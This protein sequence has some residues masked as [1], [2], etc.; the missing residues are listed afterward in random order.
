VGVPARITFPDVLFVP[1]MTVNLLSARRLLLAG[2]TTTI[3]PDDSCTLTRPG[4]QPLQAQAANGHFA[5]R[6]VGIMS[7]LALIARAPTRTH[8]DEEDPLLAMTTIN[9]AP[10]TP[11]FPAINI[12]PDIADD[13]LLSHTALTTTTT[14]ADPTTY[15]AAISSPNA[16]H[17]HAAMLDELRSL[18]EHGTWRLAELPG[19]RSIGC[20]WVYK[21]KRDES[22]AVKRYK[23][24]LVAQ[25]FSQREGIDFGV[26]FAPVVRLDTLRI[27]LALACHLDLHIYQLDIKTA[28]LNGDLDEDIYMRQPPG[29]AAPGSA[30]LVCHLD[31]ALYGLRQAGRAWN[32]KLDGLKRTTH[33]S[34]LYHL[35]KNNAILLL[36][37]CVDVLDK[38]P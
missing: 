3:K 21:S 8:A 36:A 17:W 10:E 9:I 28:Y 15:A 29:F 11:L 37:I 14:T 13:C 25:G 19:R 30:P 35:A 12:N 32:L 26:T 5:L 2:F 27:I 4:C 7:P 22:G 16:A 18:Q 38:V 23:A 1:K 20:K 6:D 31:K 33:D 34:C 24:R